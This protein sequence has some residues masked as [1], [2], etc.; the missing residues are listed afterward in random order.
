MTDLGIADLTPGNLV[1]MRIHGVTPEYAR[2][3]QAKHG[4]DLTAD[5]L[6]DM[7]IHGERVD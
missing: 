5:E 4:N 6:V 1:S 2:K 3:A 7:R